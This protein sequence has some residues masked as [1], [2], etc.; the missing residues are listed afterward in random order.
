M[1]GIIYKIIHNQSNWCYVGSTFDELRYRWRD[2]KTAFKKWEEDKTRNNMSCYEM[3]LKYGIEN[4]KVIE[5]KYYEV[6]DREHLEVYETLW[7]NKLKSC[8]RNQPFRIKKL[9]EL[10]YRNTHKKEISQRDKIYRENNNDKLQLK[11]AEYRKLHREELNQKEVE[12]YYKNRNKILEKI[13]CD[14]CDMVVARGS[15]TRHKKRWHE[16]NLILM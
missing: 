10:Y 13:K 11:Q 16:K 4:F 7:I 1:W 15:M 12:R 6:V 2:H 8:N 9:S 14:E 5:I 3:F